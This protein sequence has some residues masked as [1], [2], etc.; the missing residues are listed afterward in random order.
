MRLRFTQFLSQKRCKDACDQLSR[1]SNHVS[2]FGDYVLLQF[3]GA[4]IFQKS[5]QTTPQPGFEFEASTSDSSST[6]TTSPL[7]NSWFYVIMF[8]LYFGIFCTHQFI[9]FLSIDKSLATVEICP[10]QMEGT[11]QHGVDQSN[12]FLAWH[13]GHG[14]GCRYINVHLFERHSGSLVDGNGRQR[15]S[16]VLFSS[17]MRATKACRV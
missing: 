11:T 9:T 15:R 17:T 8:S 5:L 4:M 16:N 2:L 1:R 10:S 12:L 13:S 7:S 3:L 6:D 14:L